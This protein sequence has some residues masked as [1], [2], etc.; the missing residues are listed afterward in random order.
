MQRRAPADLDPETK[1]PALAA[2]LDVDNLVVVQRGNRDC[3]AR[4]EGELFKL[5]DSGSPEVERLP[6][7]MSQFE[8][9]ISEA[10]G[11]ETAQPPATLPTDP[12]PSGGPQIRR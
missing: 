1:G 8:Q 10:E 5:L 11:R 12:D 4:L 6:Y 2:V 9:A 3:L 7:P